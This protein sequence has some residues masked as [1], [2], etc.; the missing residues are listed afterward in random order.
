M[1][2]HAGVLT[3]EDVDMVFDN[4]Q[5]VLSIDEVFNFLRCTLYKVHVKYTWV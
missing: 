1:K 3:E 2:V 5:N 4:I